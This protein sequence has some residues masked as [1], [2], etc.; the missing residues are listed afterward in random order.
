ME[1]VLSTYGSSPG[2]P[3]AALRSLLIERLGA[4]HVDV[5]ER[6]ANPYSS[7]FP[8]EILTCL[9]DGRELRLLCKYS[10]RPCNSGH[11]HRG[12]LDREAAVYREVLEPSSASTAAYY[13]ACADPRT[14]QMCLVIEYLEDAV[15]VSKLPEM[16]TMDL[17][18]SWLGRFHA[19]TEARLARGGELPLNTYDADYYL[20]WVRRSRE[21]MAEWHDAF[22][23]FELL[24]ERVPVLFEPLLSRAPSVVHGELYP[25]NMLVCDRTIYPVDWES[26]AIAAGEIDV[27]A[28]T[29]GWSAEIAWRC[30]RE[31]A[32]ARWPEDAPDDFGEAITAARFYLL[33]RWLG[34]SP[35]RTLAAVRSVWRFEQLRALGERAG[36]I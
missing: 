8:S 35:A 6:T 19:E 12:G 22:P 1:V 23:W 5:V 33:F 4:R 25:H 9:V 7:T 26:G 29:D 31:Y 13:G 14:G 11:G 28:L 3:T 30:E 20:G 24:C 27:A 15:R 17:A 10:G 36:L 34:D 32:R 16:G 21:Y 2:T 18:C